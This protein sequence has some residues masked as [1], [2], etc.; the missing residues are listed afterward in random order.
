MAESYVIGVDGGTE[1]LRAG[2][3]NLQGEPLAFAATPY[4][5][6]FPKPGR[7][8]QNP[9]DWWRAIGASVRQAMRQAGIK[10][11]Q[12]SALAIDTT[13]CS[14]V[15]L[16]VDF[17]PLRPA[18]IWMDVR[19]A[20]EAD[21]VAT[22][23]DPALVVNS[24]GAGPVSAEWMVPKALWLKR[25]EPENF[26][27]AATICEYQDYLNYRLTGQMV[28]SI[29]NVS[30]RWHYRAGEG[31]FQSS[32]LDALDLGELAQKWPSD[33]LTLGQTIGGLTPEA[34]AHLG[35]PQGLPVAQAGADAFI[36]MIGLGVVR[37]GKLALITGSSHL[38]LGLA[39]A[40]FHGPGIWGTY[41]HA[42]LPDT[43]LV[44]GGQTSTGSVAAWF[45]R[46]LGGEVGYDVLNAEAAKI[47][48]GCNGI[49]VQEHFQGNR[50]PY[51]D[52]HS[53][54]G[55][56]GLTL[57]ASRGAIFRA[58][59]EGVA[60]G[61]ELILENMRDNG[62]AANDLVV[63]GGTTRSDLFLQ[64]H[65]DVSGQPLTLTKVA[66]APALGCAV[67]AAA[68]AGH[69]ADISEA[70]SAMVARDRVV[71]PDMAAHQAYRPYYE[72]Y[73]RAYL[74]LGAVTNPLGH[75]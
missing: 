14:V 54:G 45:K 52:P 7:A 23:R 41:A 42:L 55:I 70:V 71:E 32:L 74:A 2:V 38:Q 18:L 26:A 66:D 63:A 5:T 12:V 51:T 33:V 8:E 37:P 67:L 30:V 65:A 13:C 21:A 31:G 39:D 50:T 6:K 57:G 62:F 29:N 11:A 22:T 56:A 9:E 36:A 69:F 40:P 73:K 3:F 1:S 44:E 72:A 75:S 25:N 34:A 47:A 49:I 35:L 27:R 43:Y 64:I 46:L 10:A 48:P 53:R 17:K 24:N 28:A 61:T 15:A 68:A 59:I 16:D 60:F 58:I 19:A 20:A 4:E